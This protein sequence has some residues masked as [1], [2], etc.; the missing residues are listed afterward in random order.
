MLPFFLFKTEESQSHHDVTSTGAGGME[1]R[2]DETTVLG[3]TD[4]SSSSMGRR[5]DTECHVMYIISYGSKQIEYCMGR[6]AASKTQEF[7]REPGN[8]EAR[9]GD[10]L[11][12]L[13]RALGLASREDEAMR[14]SG[15]LGL[16]KVGTLAGTAGVE[17]RFYTGH[18]V[19][20]TLVFKQIS[21]SGRPL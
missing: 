5:I 2:A 6:E 9:S 19:I 14:S 11:R 10:R 4:Q 16:V 21:W 13:Q 1:Q 17:C 3:S 18:V 12:T 7:C 8:H 15:Q 20:Q